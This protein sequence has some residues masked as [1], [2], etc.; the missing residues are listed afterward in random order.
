MLQRAQSP[1]GSPSGNR[2]DLPPS[3]LQHFLDEQFS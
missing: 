3:D 2:R 1:P